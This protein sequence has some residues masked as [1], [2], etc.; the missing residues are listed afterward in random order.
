MKK[1][2][3]TILLLVPMLATADNTHGKRYFGMN[4][5][6]YEQ[7]FDGASTD[8][9]VTSVEGRVG[10]FLNDY[11]A[12]E[13]RLG[14]GLVGDELDNRDVDLDY[15]FGAY[16]RIGA[17]L[18]N[19]FPY[20]ALGFSRVQVGLTNPDVDDAET[21]PSYGVGVDLN[22]ANISVNMEYLQL[23]DQNDIDV[24]GFTIGFTSTF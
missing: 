19:I 22:V 13:L 3:M 5:G 16:T 24:S 11:S 15:L 18:E 14:L 12:L 10:G 20:V 17:P 21:S 7:A 8:A 4:V 1:I 2:A 6:L 23:A 9:S